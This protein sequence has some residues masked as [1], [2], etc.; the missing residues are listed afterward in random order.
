[1]RYFAFAILFCM[2]FSSCYRRIGDLTMI[3]NRNIDSSKNYVLLA[4]NVEGKS[5]M[6]K[7]D[8]IELA[9]DK[10]TEEH[11]GEYLM[12][13]KIFVKNNGKKVKLTGDVW[14]LKNTNVSVN[15]ESEVNKKITFETGDAVSF[16]MGNKQVE[17]VIIGINNNMALVEYKNL[18]GKM[19]SKQMSFDE[20]TK[21]E[22][23]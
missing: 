5:K 1:M 11:Q 2:L 21:I 12:N 9:L 22:R 3:S 7:D 10:V 23:K 17:G 8:A 6:K 20:L 14:G 16:K 13:A 19:T 15:V 4:R 18:M